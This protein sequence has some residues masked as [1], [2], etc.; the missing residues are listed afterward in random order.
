MCVGILATF[1]FLYYHPHQEEIARLQ[2]QIRE[3]QQR[4]EKEIREMKTKLKE[5]KEKAAQFDQLK[6]EYQKIKAK[7]LEAK[8][9]LP[10][11]EQAYT[12][13][14][15]MG[16][17][18]QAYKIDYIRIIPSEKE[19]ETYYY[20]I[21]VRVNLR[22]S[23]HALGRLLSDISRMQR[24]TSFSIDNIQMTTSLVESPRREG[25]PVELREAAVKPSPR[26]GKSLHTIGAELEISIY[27]Y[28]EKAEEKK[29][30]AAPTQA[31]PPYPGEGFPRRR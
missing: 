16:L 17:R 27:V 11:E 29:P 24:I 7:L 23:Y 21:P 8:L 14:R 3:E 22:G 30:K 25:A 26:K 12:L 19:S 31:P 1:Y 2:N 6:E 20:R 9:R 28:R 13:L 10:T 18:A 4:I 15:E 5:A